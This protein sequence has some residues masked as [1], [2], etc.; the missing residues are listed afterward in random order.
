M[1]IWTSYLHIWWSEPG[2][3]QLS[4]RLNRTLPNWVC[5]PPIKRLVRRVPRRAITRYFPQMRVY[6]ILSKPLEK[7]PS[8]CGANIKCPLLLFPKWHQ[9][10]VCF[11]T[12]PKTT[13]IAFIW[14]QKQSFA[15]KVL[16]GF[17]WQSNC[18]FCG[19]R[20]YKSQSIMWIR[21]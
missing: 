9:D 13:K 15:A 3:G 1:I 8:F 10:G 16:P 18:D 4:N 2:V 5:S 19:Y 6:T 11:F 14:S 17:I 20:Q 7:T 12:A 21:L